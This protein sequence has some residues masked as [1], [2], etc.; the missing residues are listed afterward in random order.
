M[1][2]Y[3][4]TLIAIIIFVTLSGC[5]EDTKENEVR[6]LPAPSFKSYTEV[7]KFIE[8]LKTNDKISISQIL[9][10][11]QCS[12]IYELTGFNDA[13]L[14]DLQK[15][16]DEKPLAGCFQR[17]GLT[18][19][20]WIIFDICAKVK[21]SD[22][23]FEIKCETKERMVRKCNIMISHEMVFEGGQCFANVEIIK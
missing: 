6:I 7:K 15:Y 5:K 1:R 9:T 12:C 18:E 13:V 22:Y 4:F 16:F 2:H 19:D 10:E 21:N 8:V 3:K 23:T 11:D 17:K 14:F 20:R